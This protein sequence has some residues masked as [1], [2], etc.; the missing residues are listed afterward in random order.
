MENTTKEAENKRVHVLWFV[1]EQKEVEDIEILVGVYDSDAGAK[2]AIERLGAKPGFVDFPN[3]F[4]I[5][6][7]EL[8]RDNWVDG[9]TQ[10]PT[11]SSGR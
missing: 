1:R 7:Y 3:G 4:Q 2:A 11:R 9:F 10:Q 5:D 8:G 6:S